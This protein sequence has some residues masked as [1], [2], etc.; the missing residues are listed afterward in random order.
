MFKDNGAEC[1]TEKSTPALK[2]AIRKLNGSSGVN[3]FLG[4]TLIPGIL[5]LMRDEAAGYLRNELDNAGVKHTLPVKDERM[6]RVKSE[7]E[8]K[9]N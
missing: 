5:E 7:H 1:K 3:I 6:E 8:P 2:K 4:N 9:S